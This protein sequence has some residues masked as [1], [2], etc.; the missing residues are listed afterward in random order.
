MKLTKTQLEELEALSRPLIAWLASNVN[1][2]SK[3][4]VNSE[5]AELNEG[6]WVTRI[7]EPEEL[8]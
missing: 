5:V 3:L 7:D 1:P 4:I 6:V 2:H 8:T